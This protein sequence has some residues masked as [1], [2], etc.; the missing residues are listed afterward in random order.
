MIKITATEGQ[1]LLDIALGYYG[2][3]SHLFKILA[4]NP[5]M[6]PNTNIGGETRVNIDETFR[7]KADVAAFFKAERSD[8]RN[9]VNWTEE[10]SGDYND[11][12]NADY[13]N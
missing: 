1:N 5:T 6:T 11:D 4:D 12:Y 2:D 3:V 8:K 13:R 10:N 9:N 7:G